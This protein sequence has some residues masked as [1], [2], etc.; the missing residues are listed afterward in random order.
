MKKIILTHMLL[1]QLMFILIYPTNSQ[2]QN[3][4]GVILNTEESYNGYTFYTVQKNTYLI[5]NCG[6]VVNQWTSE[7]NPG[8]AVYLL[9]NGSILRT[10]KIDN[11][12]ITIGG[13]GGHIEIKDWDDNLVWEYDYSDSQVSQHHDVFPMPNGNIL[14]LAVTRKTQAEAIA[15][16]RD[17]ANLPSAELYNEQIIEIEPT[18]ANGANVVWEWNIWDHLIQ[19]YDNTQDNFGIV[20]ENP[21]LLNINFLGTSSGGANW[22]HVN[23]IQ[24]NETLDQIVLSSRQLNEFYIIDHSTTTSEAGSHSGGIRGKGG[25]LLYRWGNPQSYNQG[26]EL[27]KQ[28]FGQHFPHWIPETSPDGGKIILYNNGSGRTPFF[29]SVLIVDPPESSPGNYVVPINSNFG[30][31]T[32]EYIYTDPNNPEDFFSLILSSAQRLPNG[33]TLICEG[34][35]GRFFEI[36]PS[37]NIVWEFINPDTNGGI[38]SQGDS[39]PTANN[40]FRVLRYSPD[41][42]AFSGRDLTPGLPIEQNPNL[43]SCT[44]FDGSIRLSAND[45]ATLEG[46]TI[47]FEV[48][49]SQTGSEDITVS[50]SFTNNTAED[51]DYSATSGQIVIVA[52]TLSGSITIDTLEDEIDEADETFT[53]NL[54]PSDTDID[55][56]SAIG[57][58]IDNDIS[59][60]LTIQDSSAIEGENLSFPITISGPS[61]E[62]I[63][64]SMEII[65]ITTNNTDYSNSVL[66]V[67]IPAGEV[68]VEVTVTT[69]NDEL[70]EIN[71]T[72]EIGVLNIIS[73]RLSEFDNKATGTIV[74]TMPDD[75]SVIFYNVPVEEFLRTSSLESVDKIEVFN[76]LGGLVA[77]SS[78]ENDINLSSLKTGIYIVQLTDATGEVFR[79]KIIKK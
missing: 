58:I 45:S 77:N 38:L 24:Y 66:Q 56:I 60:I 75:S 47:T 31:E 54:T 13:I 73:G 20:S 64:L 49:L 57:T 10:G 35:S 2:S 1:L 32:P 42:A 25:D 29:S 70:N 63:V 59:P 17:P 39:P 65:D 11:P 4:I 55:P 68:S 7:F 27:D 33:N 52:G 71:E 37:E 14:I 61:S 48:N 3:T 34:T 18:G 21:Q 28:L 16:G 26:T 72:F 79:K 9:E 43:N 78:N 8:N 22:M 15:A 6:Q 40:I 69:I 74:D 41:Y 23:S 36:D 44:V 50:Y 62:D 12:D 53:I 5:D 76:M 51:N 67:T 46:G 19:D 30:P